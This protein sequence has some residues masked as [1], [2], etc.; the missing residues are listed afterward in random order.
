M[1]QVA[2]INMDVQLVHGI[3]VFFGKESSF[4]MKSGINFLQQYNHF[5]HLP[6]LVDY[7]PSTVNISKI[8]YITI[9]VLKFGVEKISNSV[10]NFGCVVVECFLRPA[11]GNYFKFFRWMNIFFR[12]GHIYRLE[13]WDGNP[14]PAYVPTN[15]SMRNYRRVIETWWDEYKEYF[16]VS[17]PESK[18]LDF[19]DTSVQVQFRKGYYFFYFLRFQN[20]F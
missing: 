10:T 19:G 6:W 11:Q 16:Y 5:H 20:I 8:F 2:V 4:L 3:G 1:F 14:P 7:L 13:G 18:T 15:P 17:R 9:R 12:V